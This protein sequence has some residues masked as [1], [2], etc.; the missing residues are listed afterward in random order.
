MVSVLG[1]ALLALAACGGDDDGGEGS[2]AELVSQPEPT[3]PI[4]TQ[5]DAFNEAV[6]TQ[7][8]EKLAPLGLSLTRPTTEPGAPPSEAEC[9]DTEPVLRDLRG[10]EME[11]SV[12]FGTGA[13]AEGT[14]LPD[15]DF[16]RSVSVWAVDR[17]GSYRVLLT[18]ESQSQIDTEVEDQEA[19]EDAAAGFVQAIEDDDCTAVREVLDTASRLTAGSPKEDCEAIVDGKLFAPALE[20]TPD[21]E[22]EFLGGTRG[23]AFVGAPTADAY[24]TIVLGSRQSGGE[25][26]PTILDVLPSTDIALPG[27]EGS[28]A[29]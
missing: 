18:A 2:A 16:P 6:A 29:G 1:A 4:S 19:V 20:A 8:C 11:E 15:S 26:Q 17:D 25:F 28:S 7:D 24:F 13:Q 23:F 21:P 5:V 27:A 3:E 14:P 12:E 10:V 22:L 9:R